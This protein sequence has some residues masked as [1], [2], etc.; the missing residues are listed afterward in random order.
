MS[1]KNIRLLHLIKS[2]ELGGIEKSTILY[3][4]EFINH[5]T[6]VGIFAS[7]GFFDNTNSL[8]SE[9]HRFYPL[10]PVHELIYIRNN[11]KYLISVIRENKITHIHYHHRIF[12]LF[13]FFIKIAFP[14]I[15]IIYTNH[16]VFQDK[17]NYL[18]IANK[19]IALNNATKDDLPKFL[20]KKVKIIPHGIK[21][22]HNKINPSDSFNRFGFIGRF[23][24]E[25]GIIDL[26]INFKQVTQK[27]PK[28]KL[29]LIGKGEQEQEIKN[30]I[31][32]LDITKA[33]IIEQPILENYNLYKNIDVLILPSTK[34][35]GF[36]LT[37]IEAMNQKKLVVV[38][39]L[40]IFH[41]FIKD[42]ENGVVFKTAL[43]DKLIEIIENPI[44]YNKITLKGYQTVKENYSINKVI[45]DY[46]IL[47]ISLQ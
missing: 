30:K 28:T 40:P 16:N 26:L 19:I 27:Y 9:I 10:F 8:N 44:Y 31:I 32:E 25:K 21:I 34:L 42:K 6:F 18:I 23:T 22:D 15:R 41:G 17:I 38:S 24:K 11:L 20:I 43:A 2:L 36:G 7:K 45:Q 4:N 3:S 37:T 12:I 46:K 13:V 33:V 39:N 47:Y 29:Y 1:S 5:F 14:H 35:E